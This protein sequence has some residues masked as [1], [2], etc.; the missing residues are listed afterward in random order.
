MHSPFQFTVGVGH[1]IPG[2]DEALSDMCVGEKR[3]LVLP[4]HLAYGRA[5]AGPNIPPNATL[6][7]EVE[8]LNF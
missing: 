7:F 6:I 8:L 4:P 5:G 2:W 1:V 3:I